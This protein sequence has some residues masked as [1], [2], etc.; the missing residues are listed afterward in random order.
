MRQSKRRS[1][2]RK[3]ENI[4]MVWKE[5]NKNLS[6][7]NLEVNHTYM[8]FF[9]IK[10]KNLL[11]SQTYFI[12]GSIYKI[13]SKILSFRLKK[14]MNKVIDLRQFVF[15][16]GRSL[17]NSVLVTNEVLEEV[18]RKKKVVSFLRWI[19]RRRMTRWVENL[20]FTWW[21]NLGFARSGFSGLNLVW[22]PWRCLY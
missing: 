19:M 17:L 13:I 7:E 11:Y 15:L 14:M 1:K 5:D 8:R 6:I 20:S 3:H 2:E 22:N 10:I 21:T 4:N 18:K 9:R 12:V 16:E